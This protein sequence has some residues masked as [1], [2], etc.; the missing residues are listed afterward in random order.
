MEQGFLSQEQQPE[1]APK[2]KPM[3]DEDMKAMS[4]N[5]N[6]NVP[7]QYK[8][9]YN[10]VVVAGM[11]LLFGEKSNGMIEKSLAEGGDLGQKI[12][13]GI[14]AIIELIKRQAKGAVPGEILIPA[15]IE[16]VL[17]V[18]KYL[19]DSG[20]AEVDMNVYGK[21]LEV[22]VYDT[23]ARNGA[24]PE[25]FDA[26]LDQQAQAHNEQAEPA[27]EEQDEPQ[28]AEQQEQGVA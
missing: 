26:Y 22:L 25:Q 14:S 7:K 3:T 15:G 10:R 16:L 19:N 18:S 5:L 8:E 1:Q 28:S 9:A 20:Q 17:Q 6:G 12:G 27:A 11:E 21:A 23:L 4:A 13:E 24:P 2:G